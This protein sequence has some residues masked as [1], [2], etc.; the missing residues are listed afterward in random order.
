MQ[1]R[2]KR[3]LIALGAAF[4]LIGTGL[5]LV[6]LDQGIRAGIPIST[7]LALLA[8]SCFFLPRL[9]TLSFTCWILSGVSVALF[10]PNYFQQIGDFQL[11]SLIVPLL[12]LIMFG[13][14]TTMSLKD[15]K[16]VVEMPRGV[17]VGVVCQFTIMPLIGTALAFSFNFPPE[18]AAGLILVGS[19]PSGLAS[20]VMAFIAKANV[21]LSITLTAVATLLAPLFTPLLMKYLAGQFIPIDFWGMMASIIKMVL[22]PIIAGLLFNRMPFYCHCPVFESLCCTNQSP[23]ASFRATVD[24]AF[25]ARSSHLTRKM[26]A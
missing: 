24:C 6:W 25:N 23:I 14:G 15:F 8:I 21:A 20:N 17:I 26:G 11:S 4:L 2:K 7:G 13:M 19:S 10:Y 18:I 1:T 22:I 16:G 3:A 12:Q 5:V 9:S